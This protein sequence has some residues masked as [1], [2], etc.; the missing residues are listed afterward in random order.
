MNH[1]DLVDETHP[2]Y[3]DARALIRGQRRGAGAHRLSVAWI[4][5]E[6]AARGWRVEPG[7][8]CVISKRYAPTERAWSRP[9][10]FP[11]TT[12]EVA[13]TLA[14]AWAIKED[15]SR[16]LLTNGTARL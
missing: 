15:E 1:E 7:S 14:L 6:L 13:L 5:A 9:D 16:E 12:R 2:D 11:G 4:L 3:L 8:A 10:G